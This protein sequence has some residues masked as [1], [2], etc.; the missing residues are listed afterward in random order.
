MKKL[1]VAIF[2]A[3]CFSTTVLAQVND[4]DSGAAYMLDENGKL[5][6]TTAPVFQFKKER[7]NFGTVAEG[8]KITHEFSFKNIGQEPL[9]IS[10]VKASCGCTTPSSPKEPILPGEEGVIT[11]VYNTKGR[12]GKFTKAITITSN[13]YVSTKRLFIEGNV[14]KKKV[15]KDVS[16][17]VKKPS[18]L[19]EEKN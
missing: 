6:E 2:V 19:L 12:P 14:S 10:K 17:V 9:I 16:P 11:V 4:K 18:I 3:A 13:A 1:L 5:V 7:H 15:D 8:P